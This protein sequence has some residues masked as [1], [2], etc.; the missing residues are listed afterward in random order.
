[1]LSNSLLPLHW[2]ARGVEHG[3]DLDVLGLREV[4]EHVGEATDDLPTS[5]ATD[6]R[7]GVRRPADLRDP[8]VQ[9]HPEFVTKAFSLGLVP[10]PRLG[11]LL[12]GR[13]AQPYRKHQTLR[14]ICSR[15]TS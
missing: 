13:K 9:A 5:L 6:P 4:D 15:A 7:A 14:R 10:A 1:M 8:R 3:D 2:I 11:L 12:E